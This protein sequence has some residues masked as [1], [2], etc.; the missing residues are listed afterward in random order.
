MKVF[1]ICLEVWETTAA[2]CKGWRH[3]I[4]ADIRK[5]EQ[6]RNELQENKREWGE[7]LGIKSI[8]S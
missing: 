3:G 7:V 2:D 8:V 4:K 1:D 5:S 6:K